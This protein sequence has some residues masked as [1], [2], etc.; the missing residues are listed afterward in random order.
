MPSGSL[1]IVH[2]GQWAAR[3]SLVL[4]MK[5]LGMGSDILVG[6]DVYMMHMLKL[7]KEVHCIPRTG[8]NFF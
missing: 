2:A 7:Y 8:I 6:T 3:T 1:P 5:T 4:Q